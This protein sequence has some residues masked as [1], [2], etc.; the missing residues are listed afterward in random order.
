MEEIILLVLIALS[1]FI[2]YALYKI[3]DKQGL[4][5]G[6][7]MLDLLAYI[8]TFK[9]TTV[10]KMNINIGI[11]PLIS[12]FTCL[13]LILIKYGNKNIKNIFKITFLSNV[14]FGLLLTTT[15][16]FFPSLTDTISKSIEETFI[17]NY[18]L[19]ILF[20]IV[21]FSGQYVI[22]KIYGYVT[23]VQNNIFLATMLSY[24]ISAIIYI[25]FYYLI[26]YINILTIRDSLYLG[27][28]TYITGIIIT[29]INIAFIY[30]LNRKKAKKW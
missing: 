4:Y 7:I 5:Y 18:K 12:S 16:Y 8:L 29:I 3:L 14:V 25:I 17:T 21:V 2:I 10:L 6:L 20:P 15:N 24:I 19:L 26:G 22:N 23:D 13:Y 27:V 1:L 11:V 9:I 28:T 30:S